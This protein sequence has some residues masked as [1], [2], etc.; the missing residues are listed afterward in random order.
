M[1]K[2]DFISLFA[3][4]GNFATKIEAEKKLNSFLE[5]IEDVL[6][7]GDEVN[8]IGWGKWE[9]KAKP[10]RVGRNPQTGKEIKIA[11]KKVVS[12]KVGKKLSDKVKD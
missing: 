2:K 5:T 9:V 3:E 12:F 7:K 6:V 4:K 11:A 8:F 10:A 1:N